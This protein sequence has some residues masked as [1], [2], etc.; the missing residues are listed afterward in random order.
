MVAAVPKLE[1]NEIISELGDLMTRFDASE[2]EIQKIRKRIGVLWQ[3]SALLPHEYHMAMAMSDVLTGKR[4][5]AEAAVRNSLQ[6]APKDEVVAMNGLSVY[7]RFCCVQEQIDLMHVICDSFPDNKKILRCAI[8]HAHDVLQFSFARE[9]L[10]KFDKLAINDS[11]SSYPTKPHFMLTLQAAES[12][13]M[14]DKDLA[15]RLS[16]AVAAVRNFGNEVRQTT[17]LTLDD[18]SIMLHLHIDADYRQCAEA[19]FAIA[20]ALV[21]NFEDTAVELVSIICLPMNVVSE[22]APTALEVA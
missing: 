2:F 22:F 12:F 17:S 20:D 10:A 7:A 11:A 19:N 1:I 16:T 21:E 4:Q 15:D 6:L 9:I 14:S 18:G 13:G 3:K 8:M 5:N